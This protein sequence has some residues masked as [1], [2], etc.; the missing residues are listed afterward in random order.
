M[1]FLHA[2]CN[3]MVASGRQRVCMVSGYT[4]RLLKAAFGVGG[5]GMGPRNQR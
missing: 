3:C 1:D 5:G 2:K 4:I